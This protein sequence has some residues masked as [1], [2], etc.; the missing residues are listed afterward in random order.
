MTLA[1][2]QFYIITSAEDV[3][4]IYKNVESFTFDIFVRDIMVAFGASA[5]AID[6]MWSF[7]PDEK[8]S[9]GFVASVPNPSNKC[10]AQLTREFHRQQ[11]HPGDQQREL[12]DKFLFY[13]NGS[14]VWEVIS[15]ETVVRADN[16]NDENKNSTITRLSLKKWCSDVLLQAATKAFFGESLLNL[17]PDL[18]DNFVDFDDNSWML[19]YRFPRFLAQSMYRAKDA[20]IDGLEKYFRTPTHCRTD[21]AWFVRT[22][23]R[24]QRQLGIGDRDI[25]TLILMVYWV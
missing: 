4:A 11:L 20:A 13:I 3:A 12:S 10:L 18:L 1:G 9:H 24:E 16:D 23:E 7:P 21:A 22:L 2:E 25:A 5:I 19:M 6:K 17:Q 8:N 15:A 14:L